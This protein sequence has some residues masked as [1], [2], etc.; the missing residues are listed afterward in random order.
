MEIIKKHIINENKI[1]KILICGIGS[2][3]RKYIK[4]IK[5]NWPSIKIRILDDQP[6]EF[7]AKYRESCTNFGMLN[8]SQVSELIIFLL[9]NNSEAINGQNIIIDDGWSM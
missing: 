7:L 9:S 6:K 1:K 5:Q 8:S 4:I 3:G 2:I